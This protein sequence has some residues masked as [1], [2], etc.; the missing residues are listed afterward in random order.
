[1]VV[2]T[3]P[4]LRDSDHTAEGG[5]IDDARNRQ[6]RHRRIGAALLAAALVIG[7]LI[8]GLVGGGGGSNPARLGRTHPSSATPGT[9]ALGRSSSA[10]AAPFPGVAGFGLLAPRVGWVINT[11][12]L[13]LTRDAWRSR[14]GLALD[15]GH[16]VGFTGWSSSAGP[17]Q[18][19]LSY[20]NDDLTIPA[21]A[22]AK[23]WD[24]RVRAGIAV[25]ADAGRTWST[26]R[27][28]SRV[29]PG[30][31]SFLN[32]RVG[33]AL[34]YRPAA[35]H[36]PW[37]G[38]YE[39]RNGARTWTRIARRVPV[40]GALS[41]GSARDGLAG[42]FAL[43]SG[44]ADAVVYRTGDGGR[45][46]IRTPL[47]GMANGFNCE[48][49]HLF[50]SGRGVVL[51]L[52]DPA[53]PGRTRV[54]VYT[55]RNNGVSWTPHTLPDTSRL[56]S[57]VFYVPFAAPNARDLFAWV[58][59]FLYVSQDGGTAWSRHAEPELVPAGALS[60]SGPPFSDIAFANRNYGWY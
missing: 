28:V 38:L 60:V 23:T 51:A 21:W 46:W 41:F 54:V 55:T 45:T 17:D 34:G 25:T 39:T 43:D 42:G 33:F 58:S 14:D 2:T 53:Q 36:D 19:A 20:A 40:R 48:V 44:L 3:P 7:A 50:P 13:Y 24:A 30:A 27:F 29:S 31:V 49:P 16:K 22:S 6:R 26:H 15:S 32:S 9:H 52:T 56:S 37:P 59:P 47:C 57:N 11:P 1:M 18:L 8:A 12:H 35:H 4:P 10:P 5:V